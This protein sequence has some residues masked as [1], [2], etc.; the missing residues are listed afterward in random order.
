MDVP[1]N[2]QWAGKVKCLINA[3]SVQRFWEII[4]EMSE[5]VGILIGLCHSIVTQDLGMRW[6]AAMFVPKCWQLKRR[7]LLVHSHWLASMRTVK[8]R[9]FRKHYHW[10]ENM[11]LWLQS[12]NKGPVISLESSFVPMAK[13]SSLRSKQNKS[14]AYSLLRSRWCCVS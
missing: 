2:C 7:R 14:I 10:W 3:S 9:L 1:D 8:C 4:R 6:V 5:E 13:E 12:W 11:N